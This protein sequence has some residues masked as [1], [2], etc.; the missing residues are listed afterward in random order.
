[1]YEY[2]WEYASYSPVQNFDWITQKNI[3]VHGGSDINFVDKQD[4]YLPKLEISSKK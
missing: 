3:L 4:P 1:M 2:D